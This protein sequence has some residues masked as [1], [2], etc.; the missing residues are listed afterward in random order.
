MAA[1][2]QQPIQKEKRKKSRSSPLHFDPTTERGIALSG[3]HLINSSI[4]PVRK[5]SSPETVSAT[6]LKVT[7]TRRAMAM[8]WHSRYLQPFRTPTRRSGTFACRKGRQSGCVAP[9]QMH[10]A[11]RCSRLSA[12]LLSKASVFGSVPR[13]NGKKPVG[14][15][16]NGPNEGGIG[17]SQQ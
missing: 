14:V 16:S 9:S 2:H 5:I 11:N 3:D 1:P 4:D 7:S 6:T 17:A 13:I 8:A 15:L 12:I 10:S